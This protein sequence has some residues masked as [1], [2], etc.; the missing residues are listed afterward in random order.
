[1]A[2]GSSLCNLGQFGKNFAKL[3]M[4]ASKKMMKL[5]RVARGQEKECGFMSKLVEGS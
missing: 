1:M 2:K 3:S 4:K 5:N